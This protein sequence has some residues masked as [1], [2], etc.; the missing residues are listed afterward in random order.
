M[1][2][3]QDRYSD[4]TSQAQANL[5]G[6]T[7]YVSDSTLKYFKARINWAHI[8]H[9]GLFF[10]IVESLPIG[11]FD[12]PRRFRFQVFDLFGTRLRT[13]DD[14]NE[15]PTFR[16]SQ[17]ATEAL[18]EYAK[19]INPKAYYDQIMPERLESLRKEHERNLATIKRIVTP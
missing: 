7:H 12:G 13:E 19:N 15:Q 6:R 17:Q 14:D 2:P 1:T 10:G 9:N 5:N 16:K 4:P 8:L 3:Y 11:S 18:S